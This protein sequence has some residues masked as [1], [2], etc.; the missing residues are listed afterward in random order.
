[1]REREKGEKVQERDGGRERT[2][3]RDEG[4]GESERNGEKMRK[5][6]RG[7][8]REQERKIER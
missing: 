2:R 8:E 3:Q 6:D 4:G 1:M 7:T 5:R